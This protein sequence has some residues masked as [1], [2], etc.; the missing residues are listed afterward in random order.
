MYNKILL[1]N[2]D[3]TYLLSERM[4][5]NGFFF[6]NHDYVCLLIFLY[7]TELIKN[8]LVLYAASILM[9]TWKYLES[10]LKILFTWDQ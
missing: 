2:I 1:F 3:E 10:S 6:L 9:N 4:I 5:H 8:E 7:N